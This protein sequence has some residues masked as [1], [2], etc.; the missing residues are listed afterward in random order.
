V[1]APLRIEPRRSSPVFFYAPRP[2]AADSFVACR[3]ALGQQ[4]PVRADCG[5]PRRTGNPLGPLA[6]VFFSRRRPPPALAAAPPLRV[7]FVAAASSC[8]HGPGHPPV[9][10]AAHLPADAERPRLPGVRGEREGG[11]AR[12]RNLAGRPPPSLL[13]PARPPFTHSL[14]HTRTR[15][16]HPLTTPPPLT[17]PQDDLNTTLDAFRERFGDAPK[18]DDLTILAPKQDD[19]TDQAFVFFPTEPKVGVKGVKEYAERMRAEAVYRAIVVAQAPMT[20]FARQCL[21]E[22]APKYTIEVVRVSRAEERERGRGSRCASRVAPLS[23]PLARPP[24][25]PPPIHPPTHTHT[26][27]HA[28]T[29]TH[30]TLSFAVPGDGAA[31][32]HHPARP[33]PGAHRPVRRGQARAA[34]PVQGARCAAAPHPGGRPR[35]PLL[36]PGPRAGGAHCAAE[37]DGRAVCYVP[38]VRVIDEDEERG[39]A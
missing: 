3:P 18:R 7:F 36:W 12:R 24:A 9:P 16:R 38:A 10:G 13:R 29:H 28:R 8:R 35:G 22:M 37:R 11:R 17:R 6:C 5:A 27:T 39:R 1:S 34:G 23:A 2:A 30:E 14:S 19:P 32:Q 21:T 26:H 33:R 20:P 4:L 25:C 31:H 15:P